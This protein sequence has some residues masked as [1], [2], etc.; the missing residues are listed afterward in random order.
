MKQSLFLLVLSLALFSCD[1]KATPAKEFKTAYVDTSKLMSEST[2]AKDIKAKYE[3]KAEEMGSKLKAET[4]RFQSEASNFKANAQKN[5]QAWAEQKAAELQKTE[6]KLQ[7]AQD[8]MVR[9]LQNESGVE[10]DSL[11]SKIRKNMKGFGKL[12]GYD[13]IY[14][15]GDAASVL[16]A[17]DGYDITKEMVK[18]TNDNYSKEK[19][20]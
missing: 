8:A 16:Y 20:K 14:G 11:V 18:I 19:T 4:Q 1:K 17:K 13:Y 3:A 6:Q 12:K 9:Q 15:T 10:M 7:Y 5:G 2:E